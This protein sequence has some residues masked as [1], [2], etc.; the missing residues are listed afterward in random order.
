[1]TSIVNILTWS[2][3]YAIFPLPTFI[4]HRGY[5]LSPDDDD[6]KPLLAKYEKRGWEW[7][8]VLKDNE[9][10][11]NHPIRFAR[12][13]GDRYTWTIPLDTRGVEWPK[14][15]DSVIEY[16]SFGM[17]LAI[18]SIKNYWVD[19]ELSVSP[20]LRYQFTC[21]NDNWMKYLYKRVDQLTIAGVMD[22]EPTARPP[23]FEENFTRVFHS[24]MH[25]QIRV[26][27]RNFQKPEG[28]KHYDK[29]VPRWFEA[30]KESL[31]ET[32][33]GIK[34]VPTKGNTCMLHR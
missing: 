10:K 18:S 16:S 9:A 13:I 19:A 33:N 28:W 34:G 25:D 1:M 30:W 4:H 6:H 32:M 3:A 20:A 26:L 21:G 12:R 8:Y 2:K 31:G 7:Q 15:S 24:F 5:L 29:E 23:N 27:L 22:M 11:F 17:T 14:T